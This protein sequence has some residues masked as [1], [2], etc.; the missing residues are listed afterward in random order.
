MSHDFY[1]AVC[2]V[3]VIEGLVLFAAPHRW[4]AMMREALKM[5]PSTLRLFGAVAI[6]VGLI[7]LHWVH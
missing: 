2:L 7:T 1:A 5:Q 6:G 4:Q 3:L